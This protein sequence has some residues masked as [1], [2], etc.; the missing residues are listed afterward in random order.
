METKATYGN[1]PYQK[2]KKV[3]VGRKKQ[4]TPISLFEMKKKVE[5]P[6]KL[7]YVDGVQKMEGND[8]RSEQEVEEEQVREDA[9]LEDVVNQGEGGFPM[10]IV[11]EDLD[12][13][14]TYLDHTWNIPAVD[15]ILYYR[16]NRL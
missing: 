6:V 1:N 10:M 16:V 13:P 14:G 9:R 5:M 11:H 2:M 4:R 7:E 8:G 3:K 12:M 15:I